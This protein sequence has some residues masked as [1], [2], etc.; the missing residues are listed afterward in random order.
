MEKDDIEEEIRK[1]LSEGLPNFELQ[2]LQMEQSLRQGP[3]EQGHRVL[4]V[5]GAGDVV[6]LVAAWRKGGGRDIPL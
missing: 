2:L 6:G 5:L 1:V 3:G 4:Q